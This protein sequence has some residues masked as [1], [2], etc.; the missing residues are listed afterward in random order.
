M[1][2]ILTLTKAPFFSI[3]IATYNSG[4]LLVQA[5]ESVFSQDFDDY[6]ILVV[7]DCSTD[8]TKH[9]MTRIN[10]NRL[11]YIKLSKNSGGPALPRNVGIKKALG[12]WLLFLDSDDRFLPGKLTKLESLINAKPSIN[13]FF[14][15]EVCIKKD[16]TKVPLIHGPVTTNFYKTLLLQG[17]RLS[18]SAVCVELSFIR[19][20]DIK[21]LD[22]SDAVIVEDFAFWLELASLGAQFFHIRGH[23]SE[24]R[25]HEA[26]ITN[27]RVR[28]IKNEEKLLKMHLRKAMNKKF[29]YILNQVI[30][31][32]ISMYYLKLNYNQRNRATLL[33]FITYKSL[34]FPIGS[35]YFFK[36]YFYRRLRYVMVTLRDEL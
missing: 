32:R 5:L 15:N 10:D 30:K 11:K 19:N 16:G 9:M 13:V 24:Y 31:F 4:D 2:K 20:F 18:T 33:L 14:H 26:N 6:E 29:Y 17:N 27:D 34:N 36:E 1:D 21:F 12:S 22:S 8:N 28:A 7:D 25:L 3:V 23:Y 35:Y